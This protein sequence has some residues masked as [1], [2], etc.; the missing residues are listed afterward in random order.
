MEELAGCFVV[1]LVFV[2][3][4]LLLRALVRGFQTDP[5]GI[6]APGDALL[7]HIREAKSKG[8][9]VKC[10]DDQIPTKDGSSLPIKKIII[11]GSLITPRENQPAVVRVALLDITD[12]PEDPAPVF[13]LIP[14]LCDEDGVFQVAQPTTI[15]YQF[16]EVSEMV[17]GAI[18]LFALVGP[19]KGQRKIRLLVHFTDLSSPLR[20]FAQ[21]TTVFAY[22]QEAPGYIEI[23][24]RTKAHER[25][26][27]CLALAISA[28]DDHIDER[29]H[30]IIRRFFSERFAELDDAAE[31]RKKVTEALQETL[32]ILKERRLDA[33]TLI[34]KLCHE[35]QSD[36]DINVAQ[37]AYE[38]CV[39]VV[40][41]DEAVD[42][43]EQEALDFI[44]RALSLSSEFVRE[45]HH[46]KLS[47]IHYGEGQDEALIGMPA[48]LTPDE[49]VRF[50]N[51]EFRR[52]RSRA[53]NKDP[54]V[55]AEAT[56][57]LE[58]IAKM[59]G[60]LSNA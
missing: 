1:V 59:R 7:R 53:T 46:H 18:P 55:A 56:L 42:P 22:K 31:R 12:D 24:E 9:T 58:R 14:D 20:I 5:D 49:K 21:G 33:K 32:K 44:A 25:Q 54:Q 41:A 57:R 17:V 30:T 28:A 13:C 45:V 4:P 2:I 23:G 29:E 51:E 34:G 16:S 43:R 60:Q 6:G 47:V 15:P 39:Q 26:I 3:V 35:I 10:V 40:A 19:R 50:L 36:G 11:S 8:L 37:A 52:W 48:G 27:A 38:L